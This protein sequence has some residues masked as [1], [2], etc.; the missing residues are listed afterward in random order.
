MLLCEGAEL[1]VIVGLLVLATKVYHTSFLFP[2]EEPQAPVTD[3]YVAPVKSPAVLTQV[4][5]EVNEVALQTSSFAGGVIH[6]S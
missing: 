3:V 6:M 2:E 1:S 5:D 4:D